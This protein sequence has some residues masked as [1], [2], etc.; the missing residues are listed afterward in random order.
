MMPFDHGELEG[1]LDDDHTI[2][3]KADGTRALTGDW[4][5]GAGRKIQAEEIRARS[6]A[7]LKL[8]EDGGAGIFVA[9]GGNVGIKTA[10]SYAACDVN[11]FIRAVSTSE[12]VPASGVGVET[13]YIS[14]IQGQISSI[15]RGTST[16]KNLT[17]DNNDLIIKVKGAAKH[18]FNSTNQL[19]IY[20][21]TPVSGYVFDVGNRFMVYADVTGRS[22]YFHRNNTAGTAVT[23]VVDIVQD[24]ATSETNTALRVQQD[25]TG[26]ILSLFDGASEV[27]TVKDGGNVGLGQTTFGTSAAKVLAIGNGTA[28]STSPAEQPITPV[29]IPGQRVGPS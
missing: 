5:I 17:L 12:S 16:Y 4:D 26:N 8:Y 21:I 22:G 9:D 19:G 14:S 25:G 18:I 3:L 20:T 28:P 13:V 6:S 27:F 10:T 29:C 11:G 24:S 1:L 7:G 15:D 2:Y 23:P